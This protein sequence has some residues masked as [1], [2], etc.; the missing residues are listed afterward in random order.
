MSAP[1]SP[2][3]VQHRAAKLEDWQLEHSWRVLRERGNM[4]GATNIAV[5]HSFVQARGPT[6]ACPTRLP[7]R[8]PA[9]LPALHSTLDARAGVLVSYIRAALVLSRRK[10]GA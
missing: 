1:D 7:T 6:R 5:L 9:R 8:L 2:C 3:L 4:S 10:E